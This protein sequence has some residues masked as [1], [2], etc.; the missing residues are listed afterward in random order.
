[1]QLGAALRL[2]SAT[3][4][5]WRA[6]AT[7]LCTLSE[8]DTVA[9]FAIDDATERLVPLRVAAGTPAP[10]ATSPFRSESA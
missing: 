1:M 7:A 3:E 5:R 4:C 8:V 6:L 9:V 2:G 10:S